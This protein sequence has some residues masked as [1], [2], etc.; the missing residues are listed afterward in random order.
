MIK[1]LGLLTLSLAFSGLVFAQGQAVRDQMFGPTDALKRSADA[2][3]AKV[4]APDSYAK[5]DGA[6]QGSGG[7][8]RE[9]Q[10]HE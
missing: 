10:G 5:S 3:N 6:L 1:R 8:A 9:G 7:H 2:L 4:L